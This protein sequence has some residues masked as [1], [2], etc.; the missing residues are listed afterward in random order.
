MFIQSDEHRPKLSPN[1]TKNGQFLGK[2]QNR[3]LYRDKKIVDCP[4]MIESVKSSPT[5]QSP[6]NR[7]QLHLLLHSG[8]FSQKMWIVLK[9]KSKKNIVINFKSYKSSKK[10]IKIYYKL[11]KTNFLFFMQNSHHTVSIR[12]GKSCNEIFI[13]F[14]LCFIK[15]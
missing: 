4:F 1:R 11:H 3:R 9:N 14:I 12:W 7:R 2:S 5:P 13:F 6:K 15:S 10:S 8:K